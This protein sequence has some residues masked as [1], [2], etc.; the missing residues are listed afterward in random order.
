MSRID[1]LDLKDYLIFL[2][3]EQNPSLSNNALAKII[4]ISAES[5]RIRIIAMKSKGFLRQDRTISD[6]LLGERLQTAFEAHYIPSALGLIRQHVIFRGIR[7]RAELNTL[8][9]ICDEHPYTHYRTTAFNYNASLYAQFDIPPEITQQ[10][11]K[12]YRH[13]Q[14]LDL[15]EDFIV[16]QSPQIA[17]SPADFQRWN[18]EEQQWTLSPDIKYNSTTK[19]SGLEN[20]WIHFL[21]SRPQELP[22]KKYFSIVHKLDDLDMILLR[23]LTINSRLNIKRLAK[24]YDKDATTLS[25]RI[26]KIRKNIAP[27]ILLYYNRSVFDLTYPQIITGNFKSG[28]D[29]TPKSFSS[30]IHSG[31]LPFECSVVIEGNAFLLY[32][33]TPPSIASEFSEFI[34]D[35]AEN[36]AVFQLQLN[37]A[38]T[39]YF[40]HEN[41][42]GKGKWKVDDGYIL[43]PILSKNRAF[44]K[45]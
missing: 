45:N 21:E 42:D 13:L 15:F 33:T 5:V 36:I 18:Q 19:S 43:D 14:D 29:F 7:N 26:K 2:H 1:H 12:M 11:K 34:W 17:K 32:Q 40:Y 8:K 35:H 25:R 23:E 10:M 27:V 4:G 22:N 20:I 44:S 3:L 6:P 9:N 39:Y 38:F 28:E 16:I 41:Y 24:I 30:F 37:A 31:E